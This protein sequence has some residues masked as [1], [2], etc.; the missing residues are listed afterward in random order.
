MITKSQETRGLLLQAAVRRVLNGVSW[1]RCRVHFMRDAAVML[2]KA[3]A[4]QPKLLGRLKLAFQE[5]TMEKARA[6]F[7]LL[8][9]D[10]R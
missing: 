9:D 7:K 1:Q 3:K 4:D 8:A 10:T 6:T 2:T 5:P